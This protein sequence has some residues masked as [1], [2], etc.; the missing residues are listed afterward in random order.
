M[1]ASVLYLSNDSLH[2]SRGGQSRQFITLVKCVF[3]PGPASQFP[4]FIHK[5]CRCKKTVPAALR[6]SFDLE[7]G[8]AIAKVNSKPPG[9]LRRELVYRM[10]AIDKKNSRVMHPAFEGLAVRFQTLGASCTPAMCARRAFGRCAG[11]SCLLSL[12]RSAEAEAEQL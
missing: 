3:N 8:S 4:A 6:S 1:S 9:P 11:N 12:S 10:Q 2:A 7:Y 5:G